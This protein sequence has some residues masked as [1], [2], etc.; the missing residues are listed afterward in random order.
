MFTSS[1]PEIS[2]WGESRDSYPQSERGG[3]TFTDSVSQRWGEHGAE[4]KLSTVLKL[5]GETGF[6]IGSF[7]HGT[8]Q[9]IEVGIDRGSLVTTSWTASSTHTSSWG[10]TIVI[11]WVNSSYMPNTDSGEVSQVSF[12][13]GKRYREA[14]RMSGMHKEVALPCSV[15]FKEAVLVIS[16]LLVSMSSGDDPTTL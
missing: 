10:I 7:L 3:S 16:S 5:H 11:V 13:F 12:W 8:V 14:S 2:L 4:D 15:N 9:S 6:S 1:S